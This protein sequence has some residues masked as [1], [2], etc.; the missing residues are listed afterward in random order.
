[1][2][3]P[4]Q[5]H[6]PVLT[7]MDIS[8]KYSLERPPYLAAICTEFGA[9][10]DVIIEH[11]VA[12]L[13]AEGNKLA[14]M[15]QCATGAPTSDCA[16]QL[17]SIESGECHRITQPPGSE[18][19]SWNI[20]IE[21]FEKLAHSLAERLSSDMDLVIV[22]RFGKHESAGGG[23]CCVIERA[24]DLDIPVLTVVNTQWQQRWHDFVDGHVT[25][26]PASYPCVLE[27]CHASIRHSSPREAPKVQRQQA[28]AVTV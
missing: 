25:T 10:A 18:S 21:A 17:Q 6:Q 8:M 13:L 11:V 9:K 23:F 26:L 24:L 14:G 28:G 3:K 20:D 4:I 19:V 15:R 7:R 27:W 2:I 1:M 5:F 12:T 16:A 22:N